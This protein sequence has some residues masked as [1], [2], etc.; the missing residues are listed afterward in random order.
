MSVKRKL[1]SAGFKLKIAA[2]ALSGMKTVSELSSAY[3]V[4]PA[5]INERKKRLKENGE[6]LFKTKGKGKADAGEKL[7]S[8]LCEEI[9]RLKFELDWL[10]KS[11]RLS[12]KEKRQLIEPEHEELSVRRQCGLLGLNRSGLC[13]TPARESDENMILMRLTDEQYMETPCF[14]SRR[15][16]IVLN[17]KGY[18][19]C[20]KRMQRLMRVMGIEAIC[21]RPKT[22]QRNQEHKIYP[23][24]S[25]CVSIDKPDHVWSTD[26][27]CIPVSEGFMCLAAVIDW[28]SRYVLSWRLSNALETD[29]CIEA[30]EAALE[31]GTPE[32][33]NSDQGAQFTSAEFTRC[34]ESRGI[35]ISMDGRGRALDNIFIERLWRSLKYE[36]I[37]IKAYETVAELERGLYDYF[38][39]YN[40]LRP[41]RSLGYHVPAAVCKP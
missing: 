34:L 3:E 17:T 1:H 31:A 32:I 30:P 7:Q 21:P 35:Q 11:Q 16:R 40:H 22:S 10:K 2:L 9:G 19:A 37:Y 14:G 6:T 23:Y 13:C 41:H 29:F 20:R 28:H 18:G 39:R 12:A 26:I 27:T 4:H 8:A 33:F 25:R 36:D 38:F 15:M 5:Q 24:L